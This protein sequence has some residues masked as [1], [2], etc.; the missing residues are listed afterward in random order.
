[1]WDV[2]QKGPP[3]A[4]RAGIFECVDVVLVTASSLQ[5]DPIVCWATK[6]KWH[7]VLADEGHDYLRGQHN[8]RPGQLSLTLRNW[9]Q[10]QTM[11][12]SMFIIT[13]TPF[14]T[15]IS[16][17]FVAMTKAV[18]R[19]QIRATWGKEFMDAGLE[20]LVK[21]WRSEF[22]Q[23][24]AAAQEAI[25]NVMKEALATFMI[26]RDQDS[27]IRGKPVMVDYFKQCNVYEHPLVPTDNGEEYV[28]RE[29]LYRRN[30]ANS[31]TLTKSRN[32]NMR[33]LCWSY[34]FIEWQTMEPRHRH[35]VW[36]GF[37]LAEAE[38][39]IRT[40]EL[41]KILKE[42]KRTGNGVIMFVQRVF[43]AEMCIKVPNPPVKV[44]LTI[45]LR[46]PRV[47]IRIHRS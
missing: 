23:N 6:Y 15:K 13:G 45:D 37:T 28:H 35:I 11:T 9:Y 18:A 27:Q 30:F 5:V 16:Y 20:D 39:Q 44:C 32:D 12:K 19:E 21:G 14:V 46:T 29:T 41:I 40:R 3:H 43:L 22:D 47:E 4:N 31:E 42:G 7:T 2:T 8:A 26:R 17:D 10:L 36:Q 24:S 25:R 34:R 33:C 38:R 1:M